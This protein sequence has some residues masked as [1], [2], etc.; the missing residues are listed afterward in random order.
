MKLIKKISKKFSTLI[1]PDPNKVKDVP[2]LL[3][4]AMEFKEDIWVL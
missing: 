1:V 2:N 3:N 4:A